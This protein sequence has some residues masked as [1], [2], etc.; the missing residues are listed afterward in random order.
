M[1]TIDGLAADY[2]FGLTIQCAATT[3]VTAR[4]FAMPRKSDYAAMMRHAKRQR[5]AA[6][7]RF[8]TPALITIVFPR[9]LSCAE[10]SDISSHALREL[11]FAIRRYAARFIDLLADGHEKESYRLQR[12]R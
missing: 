5:V 3:L 2:G 11:T 6:Q 4:H 8:S 10:L 9:F 7:G 1:L 12:A